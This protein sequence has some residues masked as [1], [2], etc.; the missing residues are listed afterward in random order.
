MFTTKNPLYAHNYT[1]FMNSMADI[2]TISYENLSFLE[3]KGN[4]VYVVKNI[5]H[6]YLP[7]LKSIAFEIHLSEDEI[8]KYRYKPALM[9]ADLYGTTDYY[10]LILVLNGM[11]RPRDFINIETLNMLTKSDINTYITKLY[12]SESAS[13]NAFNSLHT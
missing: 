12:N 8:K 9:S 11:Y 1:D 5:I 2:Q 4:I 10:Y 7:E 6:D 3:K 13:I